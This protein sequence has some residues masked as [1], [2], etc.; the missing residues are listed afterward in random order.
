MQWQAVA[1]S[2]KGTSHIDEGKPCQDSSRC[3]I[4]SDGQVAIG[5]VSDGMGSA[6]HSEK[7]SKLAVGVAISQLRTHDWLSQ[8]PDKNQALDFFQDLLK[9]VKDELQ[10]EA[11]KKGYALKDLKCTLL[12][13]VATPY[14]LTAMQVGD[15]LLVVRSSTGDY[16]LVFKLDKGE[17]VNVTT[18]VTSSDALRKMQVDVRHGCYRFICAATDG[19]ENISLVHAENNRPYEKFFSPLE[20]CM[21]SEDYPNKKEEEVKDFLQSPKIN[22]RRFYDD[23]TLLLCVQ[24]DAIAAT[25]KHVNLS[26]A[27]QPLPVAQLDRE[28]Q[29]RLL[30]DEIV[31]NPISQGVPPIVIFKQG[32]L[33]VIML[34]NKPLDKALVK[35]VG[36]SVIKFKIPVKAV[37]VFNA[38]ECYWHEQFDIVRLPKWLAPVFIATL[39]G[40]LTLVSFLLWTVRPV[41]V[42]LI[43]YFLFAAIVLH[44]I[45]YNF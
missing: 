15:G 32:Y 23:K 33:A 6:K 14:W 25:E 35:A 19:I 11:D 43:T 34:S 22:N 20:E 31:K 4:L 27:T 39:A 29:I 21:I 37:R 1:V 36:T 18:P 8:T 9:T 42:G 41:L 30:K 10:T 38:R 5:A 28:E 2:V 24:S 3:E 17:Y 7:G 12:V 13:F 40:V 26:S 16:E 45:I 44:I